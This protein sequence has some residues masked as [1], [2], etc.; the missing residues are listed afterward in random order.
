MPELDE[1]K[2]GACQEVGNIGMGHLATPFTE[3]I[4]VLKVFVEM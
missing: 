2:K 1:M 4:R 3:V